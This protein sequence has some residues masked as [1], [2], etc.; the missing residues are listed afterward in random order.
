MFSFAI[1]VDLCAAYCTLTFSIHYPMMIRVLFLGCEYSACVFMVMFNCIM[2][3][4]RRIHLHLII[5]CTHQPHKRCIIALCISVGWKGNLI[6]V[7]TYGDDDVR[8]Q[9]LTTINMRCL[10]WMVMYLI[11]MCTRI[12]IIN[13]INFVFFLFMSVDLF[14]MLYLKHSLSGSVV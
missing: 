2:S 7:Y 14:F 6:R 3:N 1:T 5:K 11:C 13:N 9:A 12:Y 4:K 10:I 8:L